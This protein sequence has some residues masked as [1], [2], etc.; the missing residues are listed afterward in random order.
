[1]ILQRSV[2]ETTTKSHFLEEAAKASTY[3]TCKESENLTGTAVAC[4][5]LSA[6]SKL[7]GKEI[8]ERAREGVLEPRKTPLNSRKGFLLFVKKYNHLQS[9][10]HLEPYRCSCCYC[11]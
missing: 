9:L 8:W 3:D 4:Q 6:G 7:I 5:G 10:R 1:M 11:F 2:R